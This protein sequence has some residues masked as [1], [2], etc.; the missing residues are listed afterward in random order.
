MEIEMYLLHFYSSTKRYYKE[1]NATSHLHSQ[2][3]Y[4]ITFITCVRLS[5]GVP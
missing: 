4:Y 2:F 3:M 5:S 1:K